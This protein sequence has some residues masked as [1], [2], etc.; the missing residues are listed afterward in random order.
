MKNSLSEDDLWSV[1]EELS[2]LL[3]YSRCEIN[4]MRDLLVEKGLMSKKE[5]HARVMEINRREIRKLEA[6]ARRLKSEAALDKLPK[7]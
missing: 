1:V 6:E 5:I 3:H 4:A 7:Q 2:E